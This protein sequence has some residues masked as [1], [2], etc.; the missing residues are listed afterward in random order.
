MLNEIQK[1]K[2]FAADVELLVSE[3]AEAIEALGAL[4]AKEAVLALL[5]IAGN[6]R[7]LVSE[8]TAA[9]KQA[10]KLLRSL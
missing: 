10:R 1:L 7:L 8:R 4:K 6:T 5:D 9:L 2:E 3:R